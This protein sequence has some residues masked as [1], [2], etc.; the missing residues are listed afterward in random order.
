MRSLR[1]G[2][3]VAIDPLAHLAGVGK[4]HPHATAV[5]LLG[6]VG[7]VVDLER[8]LRA[9]GHAQRR[10]LGIF[11]RRHARRISHERTPAQPQ[12]WPIAWA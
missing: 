9:G 8:D 7:G 3:L 4:D 10:P 6:A 1:V 11:R 2:G 5:L 12:L